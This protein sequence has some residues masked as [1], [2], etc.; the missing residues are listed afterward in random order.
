MVYRDFNFGIPEL[1]YISGRELVGEVV[2]ICQPSSRLALGDRVSLFSQGIPKL[3]LTGGIPG[4][5]RVHRLSRSTQG[6][7]SAICRVG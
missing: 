1:P 3:K 4:F 7:V 2:K 6:S 5:G